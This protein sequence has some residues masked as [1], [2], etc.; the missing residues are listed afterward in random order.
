M[1]PLK[2]LVGIH[3]NSFG[4]KWVKDMGMSPQSYGE[5]FEGGS[6]LPHGLNLEFP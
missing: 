5:E 6:L 4:H 3:A 2:T 1:G